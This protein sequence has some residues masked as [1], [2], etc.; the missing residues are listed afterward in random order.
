M[1]DHAGAGEEVTRSEF[2]GDPSPHEG[3]SPKEWRR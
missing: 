2:S 1:N 3:P